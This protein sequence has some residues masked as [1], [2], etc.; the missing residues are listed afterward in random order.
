MC[1]YFL[2]IES[3]PN[4]CDS[5]PTK[6]GSLDGKMKNIYVLPYDTSN[7]LYEHFE[8]WFND[9][10]NIDAVFNNLKK[11]PSK[12]T[13]LEVLRDALDNGILLRQEDFEGS[14]SRRYLKM[15]G[16]KGSFPTCEICNKINNMLRCRILLFM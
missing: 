15:L 4:S 2:L 8:M 10:T 14:G 9:Q 16:C 11:V 3:D 5:I 13:F 7:C 1:E 6:E 12:T